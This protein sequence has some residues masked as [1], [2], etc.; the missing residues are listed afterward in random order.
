MLNPCSSASNAGNLETEFSNGR[1]LKHDGQHIFTSSNSLVK[2]L[3]H[4]LLK[5]ISC[6]ELWMITAWVG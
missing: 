6:N 2:L 3:N 4:W 5:L 1:T